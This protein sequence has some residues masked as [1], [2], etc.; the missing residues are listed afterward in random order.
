VDRLA[1]GALPK[2]IES[3]Q[4]YGEASAGIESM[5]NG[6]ARVHKRDR[7][8]VAPIYEYLGDAVI[9]RSAEPRSGNAQRSDAGGGAHVQRACWLCQRCFSR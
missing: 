9:G 7:G 5:R 1:G 2:I 4:Y 6:E 8:S 3:R